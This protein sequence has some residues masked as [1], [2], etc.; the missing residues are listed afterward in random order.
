MN[1]ARPAGL[2]AVALA[3]ASQAPA[4]TDI[5]LGQS[6]IEEI[7]EHV[8]NRT[9]DALLGQP[10]PAEQLP[11]GAAIRRQAGTAAVVHMIAMDEDSPLRPS[12]SG[13]D[14]DYAIQHLPSL[15]TLS[16]QFT[17]DLRARAYTDLVDAGKLKTMKV[18]VGTINLALRLRGQTEDPRERADLLYLAAGIAEISMTPS[19]LD[20]LRTRAVDPSLGEDERQAA[21]HLYVLHRRT[22]ARLELA[23][24][25]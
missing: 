5:D 10:A 17:A 23:L 16:G 6:R 3:L 7:L 15:V 12:L 9:I 11:L 19:L 20:A 18:L 14:W 22:Q 2:L 24:G 4:A 8:R 13:A 25:R 1:L 21:G